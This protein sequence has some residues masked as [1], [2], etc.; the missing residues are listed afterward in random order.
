MGRDMTGSPG[1]ARFDSSA[2]ETGSFGDGDDAPKTVTRHGRLAIV[3]RSWSGSH[4]CADGRTMLAIDQSRDFI[5]RH[6]PAQM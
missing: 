3:A 2:V 5:D 1:S 6:A 4:R